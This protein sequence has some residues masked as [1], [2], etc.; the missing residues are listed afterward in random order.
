MS[1]TKKKK[2]SVKENKVFL[3]GCDS[4]ISQRVIV[5]RAE[6]RMESENVKNRLGQQ[7]EISFIGNALSVTWKILNRMG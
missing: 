4:G 5:K 6:N 1:V 2:G 7:K 3:R